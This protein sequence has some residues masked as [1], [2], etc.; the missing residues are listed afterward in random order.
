MQE[1]TFLADSDRV[2][3]PSNL[4]LKIL[5]TTTPYSDILSC[6]E[7]HNSEWKSFFE[8]TP[9]IM[10]QR[11]RSGELFLGGYKQGTL[12][13]YLETQSHYVEIP[14]MPANP[15][16][17][18][19]KRALRIANFVSK[20]LG[21]N[22]FEYAPGGTWPERPKNANVIRFIS[23]NTLPEKRNRGYGGQI[24]D[25]IKFLM[26]MPREERPEQLRD[27]VVGLTDTPVKTLPQRFHTTYQALKT[28]YVVQEFRPGYNA[29]DIIRFCYFAPG[30]K[31]S[32]GIIQNA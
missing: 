20:Q 15:D 21:G 23:I 9:Q 17:P 5:D 7:A 22:Y 16:E 30:F 11:L 32:L 13:A 19:D 29:P 25:R 4:E 1:Q 24:M 8:L 3:T 31:A 27:V 12:V 18:D 26:S 28:G 2:V 6:V 14:E 10:E